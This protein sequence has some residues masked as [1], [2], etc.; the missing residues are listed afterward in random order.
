LDYAR[1]L[2]K[3]PEYFKA[4]DVRQIDQYRNQAEAEIKR[5]TSLNL[6]MIRENEANAHAQYMSLGRAAG[7]PSLQDL[8]LVYPKEEAKTRYDSLQESRR[9]GETIQSMRNLSESERQDILAKESPREGEDFRGRSAR[10]REIVQASQQIRQE[11]QT[12]PAGFVLREWP[13]AQIAYSK[14]LENPTPE[15]VA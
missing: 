2:K 4:L 15:N 5:G 13:E 8:E 6:Q 14:M 10:F 3:A 12:D 1:D 9:V 7:V 11:I